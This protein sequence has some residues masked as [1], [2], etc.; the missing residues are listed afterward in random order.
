[1]MCALLLFG[2]GLTTG[3]H[4][5]MCMNQSVDRHTSDDLGRLR[6]SFQSHAGGRIWARGAVSSWASSIYR[7]VT[8]NKTATGWVR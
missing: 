3:L 5:S 6:P 4:V 7:G 1:M 2:L 8:G